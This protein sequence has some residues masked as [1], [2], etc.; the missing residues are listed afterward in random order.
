MCLCMRQDC[1]ICST[2]LRT[3]G[4]S[5]G[6]PSLCAKS[7]IH[8]LNTGRCQGSE[9][10]CKVRQHL[11]AQLGTSKAFNS[12]LPSLQLATAGQCLPPQKSRAHP[13]CLLSLLHW[14]TEQC[15]A[16]TVHTLAM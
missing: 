2:F 8:G 11:R 4:V 9:Q 14:T 7:E 6:C 16:H 3:S 15:G 13:D 1:R 5:K 10:A 12:L